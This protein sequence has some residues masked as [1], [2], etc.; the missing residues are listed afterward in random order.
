MKEYNLGGLG[1]N[2]ELGKKGPSIVASDS[3]EIAFNTSAGNASVV[4]VAAGTDATHAVQ[5]SQLDAALG[6]KID[7]LTVNV[8]YSD[9]SVS[10][11]NAQANAYIHKVVVEADNAWTGATSST[12]ITVGDAVNASR[13]FSDFDPDVQTIDESDYKYTSETEIVATITAGGASAGTA[14]VTVW[15]SGRIE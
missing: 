14:D 1:S 2:V 3:A 5:K 9:R 13:L 11:G 8:S 15:Y 6:Q 10:L 12:E 4:T 7:K